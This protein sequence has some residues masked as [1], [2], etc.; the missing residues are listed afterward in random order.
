ESHAPEMPDD[1]SAGSREPVGPHLVVDV[2]EYIHVDTWGKASRSLARQAEKRWAD[3]RV[4]VR[5]DA[6]LALDVRVLRSFRGEGV[7]QQP[8]VIAVHSEP[9]RSRQSQPPADVRE[10]GV[11]LTHLQQV[12]F[13]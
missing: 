6:D 9:L 7:G 2:R 3:G 1:P 8:A 11:V 12:A 13:V 5:S 4:D 10:L